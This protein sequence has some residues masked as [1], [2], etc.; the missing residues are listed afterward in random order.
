MRGNPQRSCG[1][2]PTTAAPAR[3]RFEVPIEP[4][5]GVAMTTAT[6]SPP[7]APLM[8][9]WLLPEFDA[10][11]VEHQVMEGDPESIYRAVTSVDMAE[12]PNTYTT[13]RFLFAARGAAERLV[14]ALLGRT[15]A[16]P[17][18]EGA[19][20]LCDMPDHG[21]W[22]KLAEDPPDEFA[23]G[24][25]RPLL[26]RRD[27]LGDHR[28]RPIRRLR[29]ARVREDRAA[30][31]RCGPTAPRARSSPTRRAPRRSTRNPAR[32]SSATGGSC[33]P[34]SR[35]SCARSCTPSPRRCADA[36]PD[37]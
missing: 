22:V 18:P 27:R 2:R 30:A 25:D 19:L 15:T 21:E 13:V 9:D 28:R 12:I 7:A 8:L 31:S 33:G 34:A 6:T 4:R 23:F 11:I 17:V 36:S 5:I 26:G 14:N 3:R 32:T 10:T 20:R 16:A 35:S 1:L 24:V 37:P 29:P